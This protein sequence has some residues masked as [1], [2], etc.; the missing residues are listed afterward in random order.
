MIK[1]DCVDQQGIYEVRQCT[2][3]DCSL[4]FPMPRGD[5]PGDRCPRCGAL[6]TVAAVINTRDEIRTA[7]TPLA[8]TDPLQIAP[9]PFFVLLDNIRSLFNVGSIFRSADGAGVAHLYL[10][11]ITPTPDQPKLTKTALGAENSVPWSQYNNSLTCLDTLHTQGC[12]IWALEAT[13][14]ATSIF[15]APLPAQPL[16]LILGSEV[17]GVDPALLEKSDRVV[18]LPMRGVK[19]S[20]N[21][22]TAFGAAAVVLA[23]RIATE[24]G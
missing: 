15:S 13:A 3:R 23:H 12:Q 10:C 7:E 24:S 17:T 9:L 14:H 6:T 4:R 19:R 2:A 18:A 1:R 8:T 20:L 11:G 5:Y 22:A 21:V 16:A